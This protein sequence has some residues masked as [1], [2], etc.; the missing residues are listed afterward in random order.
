ML[1][2]LRKFEEDNSPYSAE[3][4]EPAAEADVDEGSNAEELSEATISKLMAQ[5]FACPHS[6]FVLLT[7][8][9]VHAEPLQQ[10]QQ[11]YGSACEKWFTLSRFAKPCN[12]MHQAAARQNGTTGNP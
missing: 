11:I 5:A 3:A 4:M 7:I 2:I 12:G 1:E 6:L 9:T 8:I 10:I